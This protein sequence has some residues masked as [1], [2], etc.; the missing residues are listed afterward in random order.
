MARVTDATPAGKMQAF[1]EAEIA[2]KKGLKLPGIEIVAYDI[3]KIEGCAQK[4]IEI[5]NEILRDFS[6]KYFTF[7]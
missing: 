5:E 6:G 4:V 7:R 3:K 2:S 1:Y